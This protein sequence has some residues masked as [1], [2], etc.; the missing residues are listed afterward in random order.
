MR[1]V[2]FRCRLRVSMV[3]VRVRCRVRVRMARVGSRRRVRGMGGFW[4][5]KWGRGCR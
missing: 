2:R 3:G 1:R 4:R 5:E